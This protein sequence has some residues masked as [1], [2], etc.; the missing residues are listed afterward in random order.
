M[1]RLAAASSSCAAFYTHSGTRV[2]KRRE[3]WRSLYRI[4]AGSEKYFEEVASA[5]RSGRLP[6]VNHIMRT[7]S[8]YGLQMH[9]EKL[10]ERAQKYGAPVPDR[11]PSA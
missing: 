11:S 4:L 1:Q 9:M 6:D 2:T 8:R 10:G 7:A 5:C 3:Y